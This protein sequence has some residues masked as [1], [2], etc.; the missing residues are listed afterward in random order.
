MYKIKNIASIGGDS[1]QKFMVL[2]LKNKGFNADEINVL[3]DNIYYYDA[4]IL[5]LPTTNDGVYINGSSI[6]ISDFLSKI[7]K[8]Q[9]VFLGK[10]GSEIK[11]FQTFGVSF[12]DYYLRDE[13]A[14]K[15]AEPTAMGVLSYVL[16]TST[17]T[18]NKRKILVVGYGNCA[19]EIGKI[20]HDLGGVVTVASRTYLSMAQS[21]ANGL[22]SCHIRDIKNHIK[23][24]EIIINTVPNTVFV[25][26][27][28]DEINQ[29][30]V[31]IDI[32]SF[33]YGFDYDYAKKIGKKI[34]L[35]PSIPGKYFPQTAGEIIADTII[36]IIEEGN[37]E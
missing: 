18:L 21:Q 28:I 9:L 29:N 35:M 11:E 14:L 30:T 3:D 16:N 8:N 10:I 13:F 26:S 5:P 6:K 36:N 32:A 33:P 22:N 12:F 1:R 20:F 15:N 2:K 17:K 25:S 7:K 34:T 27:L 31:I 19:K 4:V 23:E 24:S 37:C